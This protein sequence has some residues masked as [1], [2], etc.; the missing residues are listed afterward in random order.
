MSEALLGALGSMAI[1]LLFI[2]LSPARVR[3]TPFTSNNGGLIHVPAESSPLSKSTFLKV[4]ESPSGASHN[5]SDADI[6]RLGTAVIKR[7]P[8]MKWVRTTLNRGPKRT[9]GMS[10]AKLYK[11]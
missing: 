6:F 9:T 3:T 10:T 8:R 4:Y 7:F 1:T 11:R 2:K 5:R